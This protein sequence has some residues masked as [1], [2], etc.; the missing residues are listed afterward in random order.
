VTVPGIY[1]MMTVRDVAHRLSAS[2]ELVYKLCREGAL[3]HLRLGTGRGAIRI[4]EGDLAAYL[5][6]THAPAGAVEGAPTLS[7]SPSSPSSRPSPYLRVRDHVGERLA[8]SAAH[9]AKA[10]ARA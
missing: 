2:P 3:G 5:D 9:R 10:K 7:P 1:N 6:R 8:R 4:T